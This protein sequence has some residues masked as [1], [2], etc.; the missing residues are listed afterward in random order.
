MNSCFILHGSF[1][2]SETK[3]MLLEVGYS[4]LHNDC[5]QKQFYFT[6]RILIVRLHVIIKKEIHFI[7]YSFIYLI[8]LVVFN[9]SY[10]KTRF[11]QIKYV[12]SDYE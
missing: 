12:I 5:L 2:T 6:F 10:K 1:I 7:F 3:M 8:M 4:L 11:S 9:K